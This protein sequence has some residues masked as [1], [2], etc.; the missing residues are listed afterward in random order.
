MEMSILDS[1]RNIEKDIFYLFQRTNEQKF[2]AKLVNF[3]E[4][5]LVVS[6]YKNLENEEK[7]GTLTKRTIPL[8]WI[9]NVFPVDDS[10]N[11]ELE[12]LASAYDISLEFIEEIE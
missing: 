5:I 3:T 8:I 10:L 11:I 2:I 9:K 6:S 12:H 4:K 1:L 7:D